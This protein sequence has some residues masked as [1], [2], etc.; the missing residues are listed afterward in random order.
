MLPA[1]PLLLVTLLGGVDCGSCGL[2][3][4]DAG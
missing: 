3:A 2:A 4:P 1:L